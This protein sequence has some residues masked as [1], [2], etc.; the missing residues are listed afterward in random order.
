MIQDA[1]IR[2]LEVIGQSVKDI[3]VDEL[4][5]SQPGVPWAQV[6][7]A[8][9]ILAHHYLG[10][11]LNL[12]WRIVARDLPELEEKIVAMAKAEGYTLG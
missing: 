7:G 10:V 1:V 6:A 4:T 12:V 5:K 11:D 2:N 3:G 9:N 8:R